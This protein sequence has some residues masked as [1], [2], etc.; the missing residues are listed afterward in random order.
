MRIYDDR[1]ERDRQRLH[2]ALRFIRLEARTHTIRQWTG[3][4]DDRIR[5][6]Y[7]S[8]LAQAHGPALKRHRGKSPQRIGLFLRSARLRQEAAVLASL[9]RLLGALPER[10]ENAVATPG[11]RAGSGSMLAAGAPSL[12]RAELLCHAYESYRA[13]LREPLLT[14]E[15]AVF[16]VTSLLR[17][18]ELA[19]ATCERCHALFVRDRWALQPASC[20]ACG[21]EA[22]Q[23][24]S[25]P[26][27]ARGVARST[28]ARA[29][30]LEPHDQA[31]PTGPAA[32]ARPGSPGTLAA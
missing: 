2:V 9:C 6:L 16:L 18:D 20:E 24:A 23:A 4:S 21:W 1:Y 29:D 10:A 26:L 3:L 31:E 17:A 22:Q 15:H 27:S 12:R 8:Y 5:K 32:T 28:P 14:F 13:L 30:R 25:A 11:L 7:R 19:C